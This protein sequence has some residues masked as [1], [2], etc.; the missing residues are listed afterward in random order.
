MQNSHQPSDLVP[1]PEKEASKKAAPVAVSGSNIYTAWNNASTALHGD[2][3]FFT[4]STDGGKTFSTVM[5]LSPPNTNPKVTVVRNNVN[6]NVA[7]STVAVAWWTNE[8]GA[9]NPVIRTS[10]DGGN[11]FGNLIRLNS[12][13][14]LGTHSSSIPT[15]KP[16]GCSFLDPRC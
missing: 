11:T 10:T 15:T 9:L 1:V 4:K 16:A 14:T 6:I 12:T 8:T 13:S 2:A 5:V 7:G 3:I